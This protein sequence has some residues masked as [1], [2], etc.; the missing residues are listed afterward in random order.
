[1]NL[2]VSSCSARTSS[3]SSVA[4]SFDDGLSSIELFNEVGEYIFLF[5]GRGIQGC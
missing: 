3:T 2:V 5:M 4:V 1:V